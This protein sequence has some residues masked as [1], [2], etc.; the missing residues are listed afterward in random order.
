MKSNKKLL[1]VLSVPAIT[2]LLAVA[3]ATP[4]KAANRDFHDISTTPETVYANADYTS[5]NDKLNSLIAAVSDH[6]TKFLYEL[7]GKGYN[8]QALYDNYVIAH[9]TTASVVDSFNTAIYETLSVPLN[10]TV[11]N[12]DAVADV[13]VDNGTTADKLQ[14]PKT[15]GVTLSDGTKDAANVTWDTTK[16]DGT[17]A[18]EQTITGTLSVPQGKAWTLTDAQKTVS[19]KVMV[20]AQ[21][22]AVSSVNAVTKTS[23]EVK[24]AAGADQ[25]AAKLASSYVV[26]NGEADITVS[27]VDY[28][29]ALNVATLT[30]DLSGKDGTLTVNG[31]TSTSFDF[32]APS[33]VSITSTSLNQFKVQF[34]ETLNAQ[35]VNG[36]SYVVVEGA[37]VYTATPQL[38]ADNKTVYFTT[39]EALTEGKTYTFGVKNIKDAALNAVTDQITGTFTAVKDSTAPTIAS[40]K[41]LDSDKIEITMSEPVVKT[42]AFAVSFAAYGTDGKLGTAVLGTPVITEEGKTKDGTSFGTKIEVSIAGDAD[43]LTN[44]ANYNLV[45]TGVNDL[46]GLSIADKTNVDFVGVRDIT[47]PTVTNSTYKDGVFNVTFSEAVK[48]ANLAT[49]Y[50]VYN[51]NTGERIGVVKT[52][53]VQSDGLTYALDLSNLAL[54]SNTA[55]S[56]VLNGIT[57]GARVPNALSA[58]TVASFVTP[59]AEVKAAEVSGVA[60]V[61]Y[62]AATKTST[63]S[64]A[65]TNPVSKAEAENIANYSV[66]KTDDATA[67]L[68]VKKAVLSTDGKTVTLTTDA[69]DG[70]NY[71]VTVSNISNLTAGKNTAKFDSKDNVA[72][73]FTGIT[74][75][76]SKVVDLTFSEALNAV[77]AI[78]IVPSGDVDPVAYTSVLSADGKTV[79][80]TFADKA[81]TAG[82]SYIVS[83]KN[84]T[85]TSAA[86]NQADKQTKTFV[87]AAADTT[88]AS[89]ASV[90]VD[91]ST[92]IELQ[93]NEA[94]DEST[95]PTLTLTDGDNTVNLSNATISVNGNVVTVKTA[96]SMFSNSDSCTIKVTGGLKDLAGNITTDSSATFT[97]V[98]DTVGPKL[99]SAAAGKTDD[100]VVL[101]FDKALDSNIGLDPKDFVITNPD[102]FETLN[103][104]SAEYDKDNSKLIDL[105]VSGMKA[106]VNYRV[107]VKANVGNT[108]VGVNQGFITDANRTA[109]FTG[110]DTTAPVIN[111]ITLGDG[112]TATITDNNIAIA[113][114]AGSTGISSGSITLSEDVKATLDAKNDNYDIVNPVA[115]TQADG[116]KIID[117]IT[118]IYG[119]DSVS[120][121]TLLSN[122]GSTLTLKDNAGNTTTY[123][124][125][126]TEAQ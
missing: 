104:T 67:S 20:K 105:K 112:A 58:N 8:Y 63:I 94:L 75:V 120:A 57:D 64:V 81:L 89:L 25:D 110:I 116:S 107:Y 3:I 17:K 117:T 101:T 46:S 41:A 119:K 61:G 71:T 14:L 97:G 88:P 76:N 6:P 29:S 47:A 124:I 106:G 35:S 53:T 30:V 51:K 10:A 50:I 18:G 85:D 103:V 121:A 126:V 123:T 23:I 38:G 86:A 54:D 82:T 16:F 69:E 11:T 22:L 72:P 93:F 62:D 96:T 34:D 21:A 31:T 40:V 66:V 60:P 113:L 74:S 26:K 90:K 42:N 55:Y 79:R 32:K 37:N 100:T 28:N 2:S 78:T 68:A 98:V 92:Q 52:A 4:V 15:V 48:N 59:P 33:I 24:L 19:V 39:N 114:P 122:T 7:N 118:G 13:A 36:A 44:G 125:T 80:L 99:V 65:F 9:K 5:S 49:N 56:V 95:K 91:S 115:V 73:V 43:L 83:V 77:P 84:A 27:K 102:T 45:L 70:S 1:A 111:G 109:T 87:A 108:E 12:V